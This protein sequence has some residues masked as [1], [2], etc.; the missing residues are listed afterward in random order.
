[1]V[2]AGDL[3]VFGLFETAGLGTIVRIGTRFEM[4]PTRGSA[5][6][7]TTCEHCDSCNQP[8]ERL[9]QTATGRKWLCE[10]HGR[11]WEPLIKWVDLPVA[12]SQL[13]SP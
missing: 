12:W 1:M 4:I 7:A 11:F 3:P 2:G 10:Y 6:F 8:A 9:F 5:Q 13:R